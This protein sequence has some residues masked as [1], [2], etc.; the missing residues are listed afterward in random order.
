MDEP[1]T[2]P[3]C[4]CPARKVLLMPPRLDA[5]QAVLARLSPKRLVRLGACALLA[6][7]VAGTACQPLLRPLEAWRVEP[8]PLEANTTNVVWVLDNSG[9]MSASDASGESRKSLVGRALADLAAELPGAAHAAIIY[10][11][12]H[13]CGGPTSVVRPLDATGVVQLYDAAPPGGGT[14]TGSALSFLAGL[15]PEPHTT[16]IAVLIT[17]G[18]PNCNPNNPN[19][20]CTNSAYP[21]SQASVA[22]CRC[23]TAVCTGPNCS[24]G[25]V[26]D[27]GTMEAGRQVQEAGY[28]LMVI[29]VGTDFVS[30]AAPFSAMRIDLRPACGSDEDCDGRPCVEGSCA[31]RVF[32][33]VDTTSFARPRQRLA[34]ALAEHQRCIWWLGR[35]ASPDLLSLTIDGET[36]PAT[37]WRLAGEGTEQ[38]V[39][40]SG[41]ACDALRSTKLAP[42][43]EGI[44]LP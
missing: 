9:S 41:A 28:E 10:P 36:V 25:C 33:M 3:R 4:I 37:E 11:S 19:N 14:P 38:Y 27:L 6:A 7:T 31:D 8:L 2:P 42:T 24:I 43:A 17:D 16:S 29:A 21:P 34:T 13:V 1:P 5:P 30:S 12:D 44:P 18:L 32:R 23:T 15:A 39:R 22:A 20:L 35:E 40:F 26:D